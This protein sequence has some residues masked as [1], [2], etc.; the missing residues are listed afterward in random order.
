MRKYG[1][2][3][4]RLLPKFKEQY[5]AHPISKWEKEFDLAENLNL[6]SIE[7]I[8]DYHLYSYNPLIQNINYLKDFVDKKKVKVK[9]I[10]ADF[11][12]QAP[13]HLANKEEL[14]IYGNILENLI[15]NLNYLGG[16]TIVI[17]FVDNS[18]IKTEDHKELIIKFLNEFSRV[19]TENKI[20]LAIESDLEPIKLIKFIDLFNNENITINYDAGNS[21]SLGYELEREMNL[22]KG[23]ISNIHIKDR[24]FRGGPVLL[25]DGNADLKSLK[26]YIEDS[27]YSGLIIF[28]AYRD[29]EG[30]EIFKK[31]FDYYLNL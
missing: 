27:N 8:F 10:C 19:C 4:G 12:M 15:N 9:S 30:I 29:K 18:S 6:D 24:A 14:N 11:F 20:K 17:P 13:I 7:F 26:R 21:A 28:Q 16:N 25:G 23:R 2:M 22:Y 5:Q 31:Q 1:V 3:Q